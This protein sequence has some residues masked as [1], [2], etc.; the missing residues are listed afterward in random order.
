[1]RLWNKEA[2]RSMRQELGRVKMDV[3][4]IKKL[5]KA[6][7]PSPDNKGFLSHEQLQVVESKTTPAEQMNMVIDYLLEMEDI[8]FEYFCQ[9]LEQS[10]FEARAKMLKDKAEDF[11]RSFGKFEYK[12]HT[13]MCSNMTKT[14]CM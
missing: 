1:M 4:M 9:I 11:K 7:I 3:V 8:Y 2:L 6:D 13:C 12:Q 5:E 14:S 10:A